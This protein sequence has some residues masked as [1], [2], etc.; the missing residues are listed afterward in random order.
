VG[1]ALVNANRA[2][3]M[4]FSLGARLPT[5]FNAR[6]F[7]E[8]G[9]LM[10]YGPNLSDQFRRT[11][12]LVDKILRGTKPSDIP[13]EQ[14]SRFELVINLTIAK[15]LGLTIPPMLL[16]RA[17]EVIESAGARSTLLGG[18]AAFSPFWPLTARA[19]PAIPVVGVI[20]G[21]FANLTMAQ[22]FK[23]DLLGANLTT[24][25]LR[26]ADLR[27]GPFDIW[28]KGL[29]PRRGRAFLWPKL[30]GGGQ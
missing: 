9:S 8:A 15:V 19:Q 2:R 27:D 5:I 17:D 7:V 21:G 13:V 22:V 1:D 25:G 12:E 4:T 6:S 29:I 20:D 23:A 3:I 16:S 24:A 10:S 14:P 18:T 11:A 28:P 30:K 26:E